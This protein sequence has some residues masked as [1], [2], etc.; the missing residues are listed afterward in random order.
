MWRP[1]LNVGL[2]VH[3]PPPAATSAASDVPR[4]VNESMCKKNK[5]HL[6]H[7]VCITAFASFLMF[8]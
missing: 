6:H 8:G 2:R 5:H 4:S 1:V 7:W 3:I